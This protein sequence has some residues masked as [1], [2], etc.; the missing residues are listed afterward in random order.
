MS[1][2]WAEESSEESWAMVSVRVATV[3]RSTAVAV[4]RFDRASTVSDWWSA[5]ELKALAALA[6]GKFCPAVRHKFA[7]HS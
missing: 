7:F 4:A 1:L 6:R 3:A 5:V 2:A